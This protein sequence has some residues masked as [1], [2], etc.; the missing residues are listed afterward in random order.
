MREL[1]P[2]KVR[3]VCTTL[4]NSQVFTCLYRPANIKLCSRYQRSQL[5]CKQVRQKSNSKTS[6]ACSKRNPT[7]NSVFMNQPARVVHPQ[8]NSVQRLPCRS[9]EKIRFPRLPSRA[10]LEGLNTDTAYGSKGLSTVSKTAVMQ[11]GS[12]AASGLQSGKGTKC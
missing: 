9:A 12:T 10:I 6:S 1:Q 11:A 7:V 4:D 5:P 2:H 8:G 3:V